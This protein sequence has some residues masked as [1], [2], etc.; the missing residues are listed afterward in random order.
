VGRDGTVLGTFGT[1]FR[2]CRRPTE[3][4]REVV[5]V[6]ARTAAIAIERDRAEQ[7]RR[8]TQDELRHAMEAAEAASLAKSQFLAV[9]SHEL[10][11]PLTG[12]IGYADLLENGV[13]GHLNETQLSHVRRITSGAWHLVSIIDEI[14]SFSR[15]EFGKETIRAEQSNITRLVRETTELLQPHAATKGIQLRLVAPDNDIELVTDGSK[16]RQIILN[17][18]GNALKF[19]DRGFVEIS[20]AGDDTNLEIRVRDTGPGIPSD[21]LESIF[22]P[23][24]QVDQSNTREKGGTGLG[25]AVSRSL[26]QMLGGDITVETFHAGGTTF[27]LQLPA[28]EPAMSAA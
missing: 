1:Y 15:M 25:L 16:L 18:T 23:F 17:L 19:T 9:V 22:E 11:T 21:K 24:V 2:E 28:S 27:L 3:L 7:A 4:E 8:R 13:A 20:I 10:R 26:A 5:E 12:M 6:L 14:L